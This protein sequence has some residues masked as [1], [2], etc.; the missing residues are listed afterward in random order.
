MKIAI[1]GTGISGNVIARLLCQE[2]DIDVFEAAHR[3]GGHTRTLR[4]APF[5]KEHLVDTGFMVFNE[6]TYPNFCRLLHLLDVPFQ[7]TD[8]SFGVR[9]DTTGLEYQGSSL[10]GVFAQRWNLVRPAFLACSRHRSLQS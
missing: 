5:G 3:V 9:C 2:H 4:V 10:N 6:R 8:M 1:I 7:N